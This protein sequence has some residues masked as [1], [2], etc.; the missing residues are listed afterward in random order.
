MEF[1]RIKTLEFSRS[2]SPT[3]PRKQPIKLSL[4]KYAKPILF[5]TL[6]PEKTIYLKLAKLFKNK[7]SLNVLAYDE[8]VLKK[9]GK[10]KSNQLPDE[11]GSTH[12]APFIKQPSPM[13]PRVLH[14]KKTKPLFKKFWDDKV[15]IEIEGKTLKNFSNTLTSFSPEPRHGRNSNLISNF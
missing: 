13:R 1:V 7:P 2:T 11:L 6:T 15:E 9:G 4:R 14:Y 12:F 5:D 3:V 8:K 10:I